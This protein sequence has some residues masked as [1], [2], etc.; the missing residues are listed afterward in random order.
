LSPVRAG[1]VAAPHER[2]SPR[3]KLRFAVISDGHWGEDGSLGAYEDNFRTMVDWLNEEHRAGGLDLVL[4]NGDII[5]DVPDQLPAA[6]AILDGLKPPLHVSKGNHDRVDDETW[7]GVWG[8][9]PNH[10]FKVRDFAFV[11]ANTSDITGR[12][13]CP[14]SDWVGKRLS[15]YADSAMIFLAMHICPS[16]MGKKS[17]TCPDVM[18][19]IEK[20]PN[21]GAVFHGHDHDSDGHR[22]L[23]GVNYFWDGRFG[24]T[25][26]VGYK[27][28]RIVEV[29]D[30]GVV[31]LRQW[32]RAANRVVNETT[33]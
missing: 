29:L 20:C 15:H 17:K 21:L 9:A 14:D 30:K 11:I 26:G 16:G 25:N 4:F 18:A 8:V 31:S 5:N 12:Y 10:D 6:K 23:N 32:D 33:L 13:I 7:K 28:Y 1:E 19:H 27:G 24:A 3:P 22:E 2:G